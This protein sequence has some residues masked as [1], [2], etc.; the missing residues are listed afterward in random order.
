MQLS[1]LDTVTST[2]LDYE[3]S[4]NQRG[5]TAIAGID[6]A[7]RG[8]LAGPVIAAAVIL[9][10]SFDLPG[11]TD[12]KKL[13]AQKREEL[14]PLIRAQAR[15]FAIGLASAT[16]ID[17]VNVLQGTLLAMQAAVTRLPIPADYLLV[18]GISK[19]PFSTP[20]ITIK[21]GDSRSLSIAA[22]SVLAKVVRDRIMYAFARHYP[23]YGFAEHKGYGTAAHLA[24]IARFGPSP[25]HRKTFRGV[26]EYVPEP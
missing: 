20:Q 4:A 18:D 8:P 26:R 6:E 7:G 16:T 17:R 25:L 11:L 1:F 12:S 14:Y 15:A 9:P 2:P 10:D 3:L 21:Q 22:A 23:Q 19:V 5:F 13:S 24:A